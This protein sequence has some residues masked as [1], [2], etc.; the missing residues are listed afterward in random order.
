MKSNNSS[1]PNVIA[2]RRVSDF[3]PNS[4]FLT[5]HIDR[6]NKFLVE[7]L[8]ASNLE[9]TEIFFPTHHL[10]VIPITN[11]K[12]GIT[13]IH[14]ASGQLT[15]NKSFNQC[16]AIFPQNFSYQARFEKTVK[17]FVVY[18]EPSFISQTVE[19]V[20]SSDNLELTPRP[21]TSDLLIRTIG[22]AIQQELN[23]KNRLSELY[24][25]SLINSL[26]I[27]LVKQHSNQ[28]PTYKSYSGGLS[29]KK[30]SLILDYI[31]THLESKITLQD[32]AEELSINKYTFS[33]LFKQS[34][35]VA[36]YQYVIQQR[37]ERAKILLQRSELSLA[38]VA[39]E[40]GF[41]SQGHLIRHFKQQTGITPREYRN[42]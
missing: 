5:S 9:T 19:E 2:S 12:P 36:P 7:S 32:L 38:N 29:N 30:L 41:N 25:E 40:S 10:I 34:V 4:M 42:L 26:V 27:H 11:S 13:L 17:L 8:F 28:S 24:I 22:Y 39:L 35:G 18:L 16:V 6:K 20:I 3:F 33:R 37:V 15:E 14:R 21:M 31:H 1:N 23:A